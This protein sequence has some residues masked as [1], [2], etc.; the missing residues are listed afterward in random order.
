MAAL[1][2]AARDTTERRLPMP[3]LDA[4]LLGNWRSEL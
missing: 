2:R 4:I 1:I 3:V